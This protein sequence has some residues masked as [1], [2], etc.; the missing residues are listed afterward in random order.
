MHKKEII[1]DW[2]YRYN[3]DIYNFLIYYTGKTDMEDLVQEVFIKALKRLHQFDGRSSPKTWLFTIARN[4]AIDEMRKQK[5]Q[6]S[7]ETVELN[8]R[9]VMIDEQSP[10][11]ILLEDESKRELYKLVRSLKRNYRDVIILRGIEQLTIKETATILNWSEDKVKS[12]Y[13]RALKALRLRRGG[14]VNE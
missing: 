12:T 2:F 1:S 5:R 13:S 8:D 7:E 3:N 10:I 9:I 4:T 14:A 6:K 11:D